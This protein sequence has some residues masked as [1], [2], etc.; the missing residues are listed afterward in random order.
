MEHRRA[1]LWLSGAKITGVGTLVSRVLGMLRDTATA[2][3]LGQRGVM[4]AFVIAY[5][6]PNLFRR[7]FGE[8]A[9][10]AGYLPVLTA[11]WESDRRTACQLATVVLVLLAGLL[12]ALVASGELLFGFIW[13]IWG[14]VPGVSLLM[15][16]SAVMLPYLLLVCIAAQLTTMLHAVQHFTVPALT[17]IILNV[18]WLIAAWGVAYWVTS[19]QVM[20]AYILAV[21]VIVAGAAQV[22]MQLP[23]LRRLG[24]SFDYNY[25]AT[26]EGL[27]RIFQNLAPMFVGLAVT[28][29]NTFNDSVIAWM[30]AA[31]G[32]ELG[33]IPWLGDAICYP[34]QQGATAALYY[35]ERLYEFPVGIIGTAVAVAIFPLL[36]LHALRDDRRLMAADMGLGLRMVFCLSVPASAGLILL[37]EP[38]ARLLFERGE[39]LPEDTLRA[40]KTIAWYATGVWAYC[41][42]PVVVRGFYALGDAGA[43]VRLAAWMVGLNLLLNFTL[44][45][46]L[47]ECG[48]ALST[49]ISAMV[50]T[51]LLVLLFSRRHAS[52]QWQ[53][54]GATVLRTIVATVIM[55]VVVF[56]VATCSSRAEWLSL[57]AELTKI[58]RFLVCLLHVGLPIMF[59][60]AVYYYTYRLLGGRELQMVFASQA[61]QEA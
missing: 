12:S 30:L 37:A 18:V 53:P 13:W 47:A 41:A 40:A 20:Q 60:L 55:G 35:G 39:F 36:T 15:G 7:L 50:Q 51:C 19:D 29:I 57:S 14:D 52:L 5:R 58:K 17:P 42:A 43:P 25:A 8:G 3:L 2:S 34:M 27:R 10:T 61:E 32:R 16:L 6:L 4:D 46:L 23:M 56:A 48:L 54:I 11:Q 28:Q 21:G 24:F 38:I 33:P 31:P 44:I 26:R 59:G 22:V 9:L 49:S 1:N 45:W